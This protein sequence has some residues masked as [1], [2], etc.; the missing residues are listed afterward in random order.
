MPGWLCTRLLMS[1]RAMIRGN[2]TRLKLTGHGSEKFDCRFVHSCDEETDSFHEASAAWTTTASLGLS[3]I[4]PTTLVPKQDQLSPAASPRSD[5]DKQDMSSSHD[6]ADELCKDADPQPADVRSSTEDGRR[7]TESG[8]PSVQVISLDPQPVEEIMQTI[9]D[10]SAYQ[11][12]HQDNTGNGSTQV[13]SATEAEAVAATAAATAGS[14]RNSITDGFGALS[15]GVVASTLRHSALSADILPSIRFSPFFDPASTQ[16]SFSF[17][18][19]MRRLPTG[20]EVIPVGR[21]TE[22]KLQLAA[23]PNNYVPSTMPVYFES[24]VVSRCHCEFWY[25]G[26]RWWVKDV[27]SSSGTFLNHIRLSSP[28][29][30]SKPFPVNDGDIVQLGINFKGGEENIFRCVKIRLELGHGWQALQV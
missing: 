29:T 12:I 5:S 24:K 10:S 3:E 30:E 14:P 21:Y 25:D 20:T 26:G 13:S 17:S 11:T 2:L 15:S 4:A 22:K 7:V 6:P 23:P 19:T 27:K 1:P 8:V 18:S 9:G 28:G 16:P